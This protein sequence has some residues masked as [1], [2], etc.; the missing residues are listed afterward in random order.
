MKKKISEEGYFIGEEPIICLENINMF[1]FLFT[2][3]SDTDINSLLLEEIMCDEVGSN[4]KKPIKKV[5]GSFL[6][7]S[8]LEKSNEFLDDY[9][10]IVSVND[11]L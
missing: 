5:D 9:Y 6:V 10:K 11:D 3:L 4:N 1:G 2:A 7:A 8:N